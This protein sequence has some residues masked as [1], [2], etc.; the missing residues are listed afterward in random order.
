MILAAEFQECLFERTTTRSRHFA[1][2]YINV[3]FGPNW[4]YTPRTVKATNFAFSRRW[5]GIGVI[6]LSRGLDNN[7][8]L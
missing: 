7:S 1:A 6:L 2:G 4:A 5:A 8:L 3:G